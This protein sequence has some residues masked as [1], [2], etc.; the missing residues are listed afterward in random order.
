M[1]EIKHRTTGKRL[2]KV[3]NASLT[4][5]KLSGLD[6]VGADFRGI[7][8]SACR[9]TG[10]NLSDSDFTN[11]KLVGCKMD[12]C[13]VK[14]ADLTGTDLRD[15]DLS[16]NV[17]ELSKFIKC[18]AENAKFRHCRINRGIFANGNFKKVDFFF[19]DLRGS[20][21]SAD[22]EGANLFGADLTGADFTSANLQKANMTDA[23]IA[24]A[25][26]AYAKMQGSIGTNG[27]PWG[28]AI[29]SKQEKKP[30]W[31]VWNDATA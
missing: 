31:K 20:F 30:W 14:R 5:C 9:F 6:L 25:I 28:F 29:K 24:R 10:C 2:L 8:F 19:A 21:R 3:K 4:G 12:N 7:D 27:Q 22:L 26:F 13:V 15:A 18:N 16:D 1:L 11:A 23:K 17:M